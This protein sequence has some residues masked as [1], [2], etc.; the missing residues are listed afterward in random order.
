MLTREQLDSIRQSME[1]EHQLD[2]AALQRLMRFIDPAQNPAAPP[3]SAAE[4]IAVDG[5]RIY[6]LRP[7][8]LTVIAGLE[9]IFRDHPE[10]TWTAQKL[11]DEL[12]RRGFDLQAKNPIATIGVALKKLVDRSRI[13]V[14][15][16]GAGREPNIYQ[17]VRK[18]PAELS[19]EEIEEFQVATK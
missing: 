7:T 4:A 14:V 1:R 6:A 12:T 8:T 15:C 3:T 2:L 10:E 17:L 11:R 16:R 13:S 9:S 19:P 18:Q 5:H